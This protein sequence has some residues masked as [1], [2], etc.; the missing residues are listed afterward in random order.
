MINL[1]S[2]LHKDSP[3]IK[4][5][6]KNYYEEYHTKAGIQSIRATKAGGGV[7]VEILCQHPSVL[8]GKKGELV[9]GLC[10]SLSITLD[11]KVKVDIKH[12]DVW[13]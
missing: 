9:K 7:Y 6:I 12:K 10:N 5:I 13:N 2:K 11:Y 8:I 4:R 3:I 1:F